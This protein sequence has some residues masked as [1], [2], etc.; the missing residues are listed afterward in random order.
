MAVAI[1]VSKTKRRGFRG[2]TSAGTFAF[3]MNLPTMLCLGLVLA[4]PVI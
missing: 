1:P 4:F 3:L 2:E